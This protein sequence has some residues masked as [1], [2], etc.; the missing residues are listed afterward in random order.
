ARFV[1]CVIHGAHSIDGKA[2]VAAAGTDRITVPPRWI[3]LLD[4][5]LWGLNQHL[6]PTGFIVETSP[7]FFADIR[8]VAG[9]FML[10][11]RGDAAELDAAVADAVH[12][13]EFQSEFE[14]FE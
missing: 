1:F 3:E 9:K 13:P 6:I 7:V 10:L 4:R 11:L 8:L 14:I 12:Q 2:D 5:R